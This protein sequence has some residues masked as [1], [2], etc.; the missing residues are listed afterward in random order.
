MRIQGDGS[1]SDSQ[2]DL[3][4][5][6][7][8]KAEAATEADNAQAEADDRIDVFVQ[9]GSDEAASASSLQ[10]GNLINDNGR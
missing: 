4:K 8:M 1:L 7:G 10:N 3:L 9:D 2:P 6:V 5:V